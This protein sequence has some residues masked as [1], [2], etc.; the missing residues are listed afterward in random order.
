MPA[1]VWLRVGWLVLAADV[2]Y[3]IWE[4][5]QPEGQQL[6]T[7]HADL[8]VVLYYGGALLFAGLLLVGY[9]VWR[10]NERAREL[11]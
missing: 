1:S 5:R 6:S 2:A 4:W 10:V 8:N 9:L 7:W 3:W 11:R